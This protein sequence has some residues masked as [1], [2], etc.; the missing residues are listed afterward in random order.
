MHWSAEEIVLVVTGVLFAGI[1]A[2]SYLP[3]VELTLTSRLAFAIGAV[4]FIGAAVTLAG[5][6]SASYPPLLWILPLVPLMVIGVLIR[7]AVVGGT[8]AAPQS[9]TAMG[10]QG[11]HEMRVTEL[12]GPAP[13]D[14]GV[15]IGRALAADPHASPEQLAELAYAQ[16]VLRPL[17]ASNP[18]TPANLLEWLASLGDPDVQ[19]AIGTRTAH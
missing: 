15:G 18:A 9:S 4:V 19:R 11:E 7:D 16:P 6:E 12:L 2:S 3:Q 17:V 5:V 13:G 1:V 8:A 10:A 14:S